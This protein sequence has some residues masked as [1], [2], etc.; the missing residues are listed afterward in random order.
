MMQLRKKLLA[1]IYLLQFHGY[2]FLSALLKLTRTHHYSTFSV[3]VVFL[4]RLLNWWP[5]ISWNSWQQPGW[6]TYKTL[7]KPA[8]HCKWQWSHCVLNATLPCLTGNCQNTCHSVSCTASLLPSATCFLQGILVSQQRKMRILFLLK[9][10]HFDGQVPSCT[11]GETVT[12]N[13][14]YIWIINIFKKAFFIC[15]F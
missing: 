11:A 15:L 10:S 13:Y 14:Q 2:I 5:Y 7:Y 6:F 9:L 12:K 4:E 3:A 8:Q 1:V